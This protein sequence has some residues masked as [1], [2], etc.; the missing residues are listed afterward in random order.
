MKVLEVYYMVLE[1][2]SLNEQ[3]TPDRLNL[4]RN[5]VT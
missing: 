2:L 5:G 3:L 4:F 1:E